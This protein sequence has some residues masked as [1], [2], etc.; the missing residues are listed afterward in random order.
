MDTNTK[1][2]LKTFDGTNLPDSMKELRRAIYKDEVGYLTDETLFNDDD[3]LGVHLGLFNTDTK[4]IIASIHAYPANQGEFQRHSGLAAD[5]LQSGIFHTRMM[6]NPNYRARGYMALMVYLSLRYARKK[7]KSRV[8][9]YIEDRQLPTRRLLDYEE[10]TELNKR[11]I[12]GNNGKVYSFIPVTKDLNQALIR[13]YEKI[14]RYLKPFANKFVA[15]DAVEA[16]ETRLTTFLD[17]NPWFKT[18]N[19]LEMT[20]NHYVKTMSNVHQFVRYTTRILG[21]AVHLT[22]ESELRRHFI[23]HLQGEIDHEKIIE[24]DLG[25]LGCDIDYVTNKM[26]PS[27]ENQQFMVLQESL[28]G[29]H[30]DP[31]SYIGVP[32]CIEGFT[33]QLSTK[34]LGNLEKCIKNWG[35]K[36]P[37]K[38]MSFITSHVAFDGGDDGHWEQNKNI[39]KKYIQNEIN[40]QKFLNVI[41]LTMDAI[42]ASYA[43]YVQE[44]DFNVKDSRANIG[45]KAA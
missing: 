17:T 41:G 25:Y 1:L 36:S 23:H 19:N 44:P 27:K 16:V 22:E 4:E 24:T 28:L 18:I 26:V 21:L 34:F 11:E 2:E 37:K 42:E 45:R 14:P 40:L 8:F 32:M 30:R 43:S 7:N 35:Y 9:C 38:A 33:A 13:S 5:R 10:L 31:I 12:T 15:D 29:F 20:K 39:V 3:K 6:I